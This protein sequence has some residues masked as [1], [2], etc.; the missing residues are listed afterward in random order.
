VRDNVSVVGHAPLIRPRFVGERCVVS[1]THPRH[2]EVNHVVDVDASS[3]E[4]HTGQLGNGCAQ[5][6]TSYANLRM[7]VDSL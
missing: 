2:T 3:H 6:V 7:S 1:V 4:S 5:A